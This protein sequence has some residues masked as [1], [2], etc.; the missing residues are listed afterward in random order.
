GPRGGVARAVKKMRTYLLELIHRKR[1]ELG[2]VEA[3]G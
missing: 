2:D 3:F 1:G